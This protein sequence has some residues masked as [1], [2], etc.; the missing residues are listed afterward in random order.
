MQK[1]KDIMSS[2]AVSITGDIT[3]K[4][5]L[6]L[7]A[8]RNISGVPIVDPE[9]KV[10]GVISDTDII[11]Y[12]HQNSVVAHTNLSGWVSPY[13]DVNELASVKKG[14]DQLATMKVCTVMT[15]KVFTINQDAD[16]G[17]AAKLM[18]R[19]NINRIPVTDNEGKLVGIVTRADIVKCMANL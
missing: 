11:K 13:V 14:F 3:I 12:A 9:D 4:E 16:A 8:D 7:L 2:P 15:K 18:N 10:V 17:E 1:V 19:R 6:D 5:A